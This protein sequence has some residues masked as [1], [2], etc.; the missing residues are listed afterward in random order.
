MISNC[1]T[2]G[3]SKLIRSFIIVGFLLTIGFIAGCGK[4]KGIS[5]EMPENPIPK[6]DVIEVYDD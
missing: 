3:T 1:L 5:A 4:G 6:P 2:E